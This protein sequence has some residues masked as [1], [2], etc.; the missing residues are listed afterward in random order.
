MKTGRNC[1]NHE[2]SRMSI[3]RISVDTCEKGRFLFFLLLVFSFTY[4]VLVEHLL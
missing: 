1:G 2:G 4:Q 3:K